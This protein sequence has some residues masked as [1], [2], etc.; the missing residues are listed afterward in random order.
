LEEYCAKTGV[1]RTE[2]ISRGI[3]KLKEGDEAAPDEVEAIQEARQEI[4]RGE[5]FSHNEVWA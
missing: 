2:A 4:E 1:N 3:G 5:L